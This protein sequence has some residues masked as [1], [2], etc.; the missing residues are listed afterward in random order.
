[1]PER[2][3]P[4]CNM[5]IDPFPTNRLWGIDR[6][7]NRQAC[8][9]GWAARPEAKRNLAELVGDGH[10]TCEPRG[11]GPLPANNCPMPAN[12]QDLGFAMVPAGMAYAR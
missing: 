1:M 8:A 10:V 12:G 9:D 11:F 3:K 7:E 4:Y 2:G 5:C 6:P